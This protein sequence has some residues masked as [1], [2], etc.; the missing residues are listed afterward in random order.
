MFEKQDVANIIMKRFRLKETK[1]DLYEWNKLCKKK[2]NIKDTVEIAIVGKY[3][4]L[5]DAY[6]SIYE[7]LNHA[8]VVNN[9]N[10]KIRWIDSEELECKDYE[11][12]LQNLDGII[13]PGG[14]GSRGIDGKI[15]AI[16]YARENKIPLLG[17]CLGMQLIVVEFMRN[18]AGIKNANSLEFDDSSDA[19]VINIMD[20]QV[21]VENKGGT[22]RLGKYPCMLDVNTNAYN[23]YNE[24]LIYERH[25]H[26][27]EFNNDYRDIA[28]QNGLVI[29]GVSPDSKL[30]EIVEIKDHPWAVGC[31]FHPELKSRPNRPHPLFRDL[32][33]KAKEY[34]GIE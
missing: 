34:K 19:P 11:K 12:K 20:E 10:V 2:D 6:I 28:T 7:A 5:K 27:F 9:V 4:V 24:N 26:R 22:M 16:T 1:N 18:V 23:A 21:G 17:I 25:R 30:V 33:K 13:V 3:V 15:N 31:Q 8:S 29:S 14:F 32:V